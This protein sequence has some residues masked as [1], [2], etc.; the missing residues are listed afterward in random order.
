MQKLDGREGGREGSSRGWLGK[1]GTLVK[2][3]DISLGPCDPR[4]LPGQAWFKGQE[5]YL[6]ILSS[7]LS[8]HPRPKVCERLRAGLRDGGVSLQTTMGDLHEVVVSRS[9][10]GIMQDPP[11]N[12][13]VRARSEDRPYVHQGQSEQ[14][15]SHRDHDA[16]QARRH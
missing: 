6:E 9:K 1:P 3:L 13:R 16:A 5:L 15:L 2:S 8:L 7:R 10:L 12:H 4:G 11:S 14:P